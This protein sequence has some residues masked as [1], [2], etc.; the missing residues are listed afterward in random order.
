MEQ[1]MYFIQLILKIEIEIIWK[2]SKLGTR[3]WTLISQSPCLHFIICLSLHGFVNHSIITVIYSTVYKTRRINSARQSTSVCP[4]GEGIL[5]TPCYWHLPFM[6]YLEAF[7][8]LV[9]PLRH[10]LPRLSACGRK[11]KHLGMAFKPFLNVWRGFMVRSTTK[12]WSPDTNPA[13]VG[14]KAFISTS[15]ASHTI[16][17]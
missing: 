17:A 5:A 15:I 16:Y 10:E 9:T 8:L 2:K 13:G 4:E 14:S 7:L 6:S 3:A 11:S 12:W 1:I